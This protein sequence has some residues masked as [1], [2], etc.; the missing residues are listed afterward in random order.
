M[1]P[2]F[3]S[4]NPCLCIHSC[5]CSP[6][7]YQGLRTQYYLRTESRLF[8]QECTSLSRKQI[9]REPI[10]VVL[11]FFFHLTGEWQCAQCVQRRFWECGCPGYSGICTRLWWEEPWVPGSR[12]P[13]QGPGCC[14]WE[15][16]QNWPVSDASLWFLMTSLL[17]NFVFWRAFFF[18][19]EFS[20][21]MPSFLP[22]SGA[23]LLVGLS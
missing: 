7:L 14:G 2:L 3:G 10:S 23:C 1:T 4:S 9:R 22:S 5:R 6:F 21:K 12:V 13:V 20:C 17:L 11:T 15:E 8:L 16:G 19:S 18:S